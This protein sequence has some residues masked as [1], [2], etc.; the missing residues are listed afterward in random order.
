MKSLAPRTP[1]RRVGACPANVAYDPQCLLVCGLVQIASV[2][3][4]QGTL[5]P[6]CAAVPAG[7]TF[8]SPACRTAALLAQVTA[9]TGLG[10]QQAKLRQRLEKATAL[11]EQAVTACR[12][13]KLRRTRKRL[14]RAVKQI[15]DAHENRPAPARVK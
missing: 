1:E 14:A 9:S 11:R 7:S 8:A 2:A 5:P 10:R 15:F 6:D 4:G 12:E 13:P 3:R